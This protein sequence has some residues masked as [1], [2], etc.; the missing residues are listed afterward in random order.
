MN[1]AKRGRPKKIQIEND[2]PKVGNL[3]KFERR[4][5]DDETIGIWKYDLKKSNGPIEVNITY[6]NNVDKHWEKRAKQAKDDRRMERK[7]RKI[8]E[9]NS[10]KIKTGKCGRPKK[11]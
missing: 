6:K 5:E 11:K 10:P 3:T 8:N 1:V 7:M 2:V 4:Y 9:Q